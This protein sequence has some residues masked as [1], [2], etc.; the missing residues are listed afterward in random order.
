VP[1]FSADRISSEG[2]VLAD[3]PVHLWSGSK[4]DTAAWEAKRWKHC[5]ESPGC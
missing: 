3:P 4:V 5:S 1:T 2:H